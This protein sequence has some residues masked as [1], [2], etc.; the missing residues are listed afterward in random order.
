MKDTGSNQLPVCTKITTVEGLQLLQHTE[1]LPIQLPAHNQGTLSHKHTQVW[2]HEKG[3]MSTN[4]SE[5][6]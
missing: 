1:A 3:A 2:Q 6:M 5:K 4:N